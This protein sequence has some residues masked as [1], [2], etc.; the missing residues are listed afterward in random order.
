MILTVAANFKSIP[1]GAT[2]FKIPSQ[3]KLDI[4]ACLLIRRI[5]PD[6]VHLPCDSITQTSFNMQTHFLRL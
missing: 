4:S 6:T 1:S 2:H 3:M 5:V